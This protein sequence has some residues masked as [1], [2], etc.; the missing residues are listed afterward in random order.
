M[1]AAPGALVI[2]GSTQS[3]AIGSRGSKGSHPHGWEP[4]QVG[5][6]YVEAQVVIS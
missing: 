4:A 3:G 1:T 6:D 5:M 2:L